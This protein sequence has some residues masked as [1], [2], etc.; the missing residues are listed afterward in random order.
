[1]KSSTKLHLLHTLEVHLSSTP[2]FGMGLAH[3][4]H[5]H[6]SSM[7]GQVGWLPAEGF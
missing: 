2:A 7:G 3:P 1:L 5:V 4:Q 6:E